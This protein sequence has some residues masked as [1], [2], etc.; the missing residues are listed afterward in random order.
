MPGGKRVRRAEFKKRCQSCGVWEKFLQA[1]AAL[2]AKGWTPKQV[3]ESLYPEFERLMD[4]Q[5]KACA[6][7]AQKAASQK[8]GPKARAQKAGVKARA[9]GSRKAA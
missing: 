5:E 3:R 7:G 2:Y 9:A 1:R 4:E 8:A 6:Q